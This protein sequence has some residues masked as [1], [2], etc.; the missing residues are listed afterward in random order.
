M[1][2]LSDI[3]VFQILP[4]GSLLTI[5]KLSKLLAPQLFAG[6]CQNANRQGGRRRG[7]IFGAV[8]R[9]DAVPHAAIKPPGMP[10]RRRKV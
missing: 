8:E 4:D 1:E 2:T 6:L 3:V 7:G 10:N 5:A 9:S